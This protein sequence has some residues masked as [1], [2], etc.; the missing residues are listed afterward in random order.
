MNNAAINPNEEDC[1][2]NNSNDDEVQTK[3]LDTGDTSLTT[4]SN[5]ERGGDNE[6]LTGEKQLRT[7]SHL[8]IS[9]SDSIS[10]LTH[11]L[12]TKTVWQKT[13]YI[14]SEWTCNDYNLEID[15]KGKK[16]VEVIK[17]VEV[18]KAV[19]EVIFKLV[20]WLLR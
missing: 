11:H 7:G 1:N 13:K 5:E 15:F 3:K 16:H 10:F 9:R 20:L 4:F 19:G 17:D 14:W 12:D 18:M 6:D 8:L 2:N